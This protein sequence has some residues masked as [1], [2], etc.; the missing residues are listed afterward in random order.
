MEAVPGLDGGR[1]QARRARVRSL[2]GALL[3]TKGWASRK[4]SR[5]LPFSAERLASLADEKSLGCQSHAKVSCLLPFSR[6]YMPIG[7]SATSSG[8]N[9]QSYGALERRLAAED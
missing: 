7:M 2:S 4:R 6:D 9:R 1:V 3:P 5:D 8:S